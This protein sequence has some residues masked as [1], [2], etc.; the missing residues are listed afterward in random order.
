[1]KLSKERNNEEKYQR[2]ETRQK[3]NVE[4]LRP[5]KMAKTNSHLQLKQRKQNSSMQKAKTTNF[6]KQEIYPTESCL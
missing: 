2:Q 6:Y 3:V 1:M 4:K 5:N